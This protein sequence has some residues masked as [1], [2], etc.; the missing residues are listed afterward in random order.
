MFKIYTL[1]LMLLVAAN[2][3]H[4]TD[5]NNS[6]TLARDNVRNYLNYKNY[7]EQSSALLQSARELVS[8]DNY[9][10]LKS[11]SF[12]HVSLWYNGLVYGDSFSFHQIA[13]DNTP[14]IERGPNGAILAFNDGKKTPLV[15]GSI[16]RNAGHIERIKTKFN[17]S[18]DAII[19][20]HTLNRDFERR[21]SG[22]TDLLQK[23]KYLRLFKYPTTDFSAPS[24]IDLV[25][26]V[27]DIRER[28]TRDSNVTYVHCKAGR[29]R[30]AVALATYMLSDLNDKQIEATGQQIED[31]LR[32]H[33]SQ[34]KFNA[35]HKAAFDDFE[36]KLKAAGS[37]K[38]L[39]AIHKID[40]QKRAAHV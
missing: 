35:A 36:Q 25:R 11:A 22:L 30:S 39:Y 20:V 14:S 7:G 8:V 18:A 16:P 4:A 21:W 19:D 27:Q 13:G 3:A 33:R 6:L 26:I 5:N 40:A 2:T 34:V 31:Y 9:N 37:F 12:F 15:L 38:A 10:L 28:D 17:L 1:S 29:G 32:L 24:F 23:N